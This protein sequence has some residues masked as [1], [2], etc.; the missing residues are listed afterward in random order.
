LKYPLSQ[1]LLCL[2]LYIA[3]SIN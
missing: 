2:F 1:F 3:N